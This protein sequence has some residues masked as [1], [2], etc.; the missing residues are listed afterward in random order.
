MVGY[1]TFEDGADICPETTFSNCLSPPRN[2][3]KRAKPVKL[4]LFANVQA[5]LVIVWVSC[6]VVLCVGKSGQTVKLTFLYCVGLKVLRH[7]FSFSL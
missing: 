6:Q 2:I 5:V 4:P 3:P 7:S 1:L